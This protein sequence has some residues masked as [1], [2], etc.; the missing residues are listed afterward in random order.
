MAYGKPVIAF[1]RGG[2]L[3]TVVDGETGTLFQKQRVE[4]L[5]EAVRKNSKVIFAPADIRQHAEQ[6]SV[7]RFQ[8]E[9]LDVVKQ[10]LRLSRLGD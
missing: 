5:I 9:M 4:N 6:F 7:E 8:H 3:D 2:A 10:L 1:A